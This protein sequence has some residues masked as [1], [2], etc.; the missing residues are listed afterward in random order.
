MSVEF[1]DSNVIVY[2]YDIAGGDRRGKA[3][4]LLERLSDSNDGDLSIQVLQEVYVTL[5]RKVAR[6]LAAPRAREVVQDLALWRVFRPSPDD[7][8]AAMDL[9]AQWRLSFWDAMIV[10]AAR[11]V[12][13]AILWSEDLND[14]QVYDGVVVRNPFR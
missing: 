5:T 12:G 11:Q 1:S 6:P 8:L 10:T 9:S 2:A 7:V 14:G 3:M 4:E 13:A